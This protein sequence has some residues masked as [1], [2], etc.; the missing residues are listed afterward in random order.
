MPKPQ[1]VLQA[2]SGYGAASP[3]LIQSPHLEVSKI[4]GPFL[5]VTRIRDTVFC[6]SGS[7]YLVEPV[8]SLIR[9]S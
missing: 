4:Q 6:V 2:A 7:K 1:F 3:A 8:S 5:R 9:N